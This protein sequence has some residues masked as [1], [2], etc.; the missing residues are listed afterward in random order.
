MKAIYYNEIQKVTNKW[1][2]LLV[3]TVSVVFIY[4]FIEQLILKHPFGENP[5]PDWFLILMA[6]LPFF[7]ILLLLTIKLSIQINEQGIYFR[8]YPFHNSI[9]EILW[10]D[11]ESVYVRKFKPISEYGG[12]G[13]R[14]ISLKKNIAYTISGDKGLQIELKD[15]K[16]I[17]LGTQNPEEVEKIVSQIT[18]ITP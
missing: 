17:L 7:L 12:W 15:G 6:I 14:T 18:H 11:I 8:F 9:K 1:L 16:K 5:S 3:A 10:K 4:G 13:I 2:W